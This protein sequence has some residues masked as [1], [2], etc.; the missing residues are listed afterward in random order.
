[1]TIDGDDPLAR[2]A[3]WWFMLV[4]LVVLAA[5]LGLRDPWPPDEPRFALV[6]RQM[7]ASGQWLFP[8]RGIE[9]YSD[10]PPLL[11]WCEAMAFWLTGG[12]RGAFLLPSLL[13]GM[14]SLW[15][16]YRT[17][18]RLWNARIGLFAAILLLAAIQFVEVI[19]HAQIDPLLLF[20]ITLGNGCLLLHCLRGPDWPAYWLGCFAAGLGVITK[21]VG[22]LVLLMLLPYVF[23]RFRKWPGI[24]V[25]RGDG[26]RWA[27]GALAFLLPILSWLLPMLA[28]VHASRSPEY[29]AYVQDLLFR[30]TAQ[31]YSHS[32]AHLEPA[33][34]FLLVMLRD[35][36]P[37]CLLIPLLF[38]AWRR[39]L[40]EREPRVL[41]P[42]A[43][44]L[45]ALV[46]FSIP[47][48]KREIYLLPAL[49]MM[50]LAM[51]PFMDALLARRWFE[52]SA[53]ALTLLMGVVFLAAGSWALLAHPKAAL[54]VAAGYE[55]AD[56]GRLLWYCVLAVGAVFLLAAAW[57]RPRRGVFALLAGLGMAWVTWC[58]ATYPLL[59]DNQS[60]RALMREANDRIGPD[61]ELALVQW[62]E[63]L[64]L[65]A[66]R[67]VA[68][69]GYSRSSAAQM[70]DALVW[71]AQAPQRRWI[72]LNSVALGR[73]VDP[74]RV[75]H[76]GVANRSTWWMFDSKAVI[77]GCTTTAE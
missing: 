42:L 26:W 67:P 45:L 1:M 76:M 12:W 46:F 65:Q 14:G 43:W 10:K 74:T 25:T 7:L 54:R 68:E 49:P 52:R 24:T 36:F 29:L 64:L 40:R 6:A 28:V 27:A 59:D 56:G 37:V 20:W 22:V 44:W 23:A 16:V 61:G 41:L 3:F 33:W 55:L 39:A 53:F 60:A 13:A 70:H 57:F 32:W 15:V 73:C 9:L 69:F 51:A 47:G 30:Q 31:R 8:H 75:V 50:V 2:R 5:G 58:C 71:Q 18:R 34:F 77:P 35:W 38:P 72:L 48:G 19:K 66:K 17:G 11:M 62:R 21:G 63:E 4:A